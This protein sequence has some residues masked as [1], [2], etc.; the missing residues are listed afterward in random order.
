VTPSALALSAVF[1]DNPHTGG[2]PSLPALSLR[3]GLVSFPLSKQA[4]GPGSRRAGDGTA[5]VRLLLRGP[6]VETVAAVPAPV[7]VPPDNPREVLP[8]PPRVDPLAMVRKAFGTTVSHLKDGPAGLQPPGPGPNHQ[9]WQ[10]GGQA[11]VRG[12][13][14]AK[15]PAMTKKPGTPAGRR[16]SLG[17]AAMEIHHLQRGSYHAGCWDRTVPQAAEKKA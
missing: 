1:D 14:T 3:G 15:A 16:L 8:D 13:S 4:P 7:K 17:A 2:R 5:R 10:G 6:S 12:K 11:K 9:P